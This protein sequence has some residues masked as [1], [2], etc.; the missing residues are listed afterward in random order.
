[1]AIKNILG[2]RKA[3]HYIERLIEHLDGDDVPRLG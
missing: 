3:K 2:M 1:M